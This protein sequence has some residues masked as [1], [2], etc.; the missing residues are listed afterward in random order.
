V[1]KQPL[2]VVQPTA[3]DPGLELLIAAAFGR[4][5]TDSAFSS[6]GTAYKKLFAPEASSIDSKT[7]Y[8][9]YRLGAQWPLSVGSYDLETIAPRW[10]RA[11]TIL[12]L[13]PAS[14]HDIVDYWNLRALGWAIVPVPTNWRAQLVTDCREIIVESDRRTQGLIYR[15]SVTR[16]RSVA[17]TELMEFTHDL[18]LHGTNV[19][20]VQLSAPHPTSI[21]TTRPAERL[22]VQVRA[23]DRH[24]NA[25][26]SNG[27]VHF[28]L[29][30]PAWADATPPEWG[31]AEWI[32]VVD[33][34]QFRGR[35][36]I[37]R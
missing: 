12:C 21:F 37:P 26:V 20:T 1:R 30:R 28:T 15:A 8:T 7:L 13:N 25:A 22:R 29:V 9:P 27:R 17:Q 32:N 11:P 18:A 23:G 6:V 4:F 16:A 5:P 10:T 14:F 36:I 19:C 34:R 33:F 31:S 35:L 24:D 2:R 3:Q